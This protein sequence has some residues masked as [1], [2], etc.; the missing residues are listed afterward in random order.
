MSTMD[1][2]I[3]NIKDENFNT[4]KQ[5]KLLTFIKFHISTTPP[6]HKNHQSVTKATGGISQAQMILIHPKRHPE[7][8]ATN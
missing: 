1:N 6:L 5:T 8:H 3:M 7:M 4:L 2:V